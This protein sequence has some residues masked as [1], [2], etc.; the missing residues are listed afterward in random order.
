MRAGVAVVGALTSIKDDYIAGINEDAPDY[1]DVNL[2]EE[3]ID[4]IWTE[5][6]G[7]DLEACPT[8]IQDLTVTDGNYV[9]Y[10]DCLDTAD[11]NVTL[12]GDARLYII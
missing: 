8:L 5:Y 12:E 3:T 9:I 1:N 2:W 7:P 10:I 11:Y 6:G 4:I